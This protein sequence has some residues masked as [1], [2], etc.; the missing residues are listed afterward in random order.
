VLVRL[1][2]QWHPVAIAKHGTLL[3]LIAPVVQWKPGNA[4]EADDKLCNAHIMIVV[5]RVLLLSAWHV[6]PS[7]KL[8]VPFPAVFSCTHVQQIMKVLYII[9]M[10]YNKYHGVHSKLPW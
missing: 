10:R 5:N 8:K 9:I 6:Q 3:T 4:W 1:D 2:A 7:F